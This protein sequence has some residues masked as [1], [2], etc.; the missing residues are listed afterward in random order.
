MVPP[1]R[2][3][4][5]RRS[6]AVGWGAVV[7]AAL[8]VTGGTIRGCSSAGRAGPRADASGRLPGASGVVSGE[9]PTVALGEPSASA[10]SA[11]WEEAAETIVAE[12][13][14][15][16]EGRP[17]AGAFAEAQAEASREDLARYPPDRSQLRRM[18]LGTEG[19]RARALAALSARPVLDDD[20]AALVLRS[21]RPE[22]DPLIR[23]LAAE[24]VAAMP[25]DVL[26]RHEEELLRAFAAEENP[27]ILAVAL[28]SLEQLA[29]PRLEQLL[30]AQLEL[31]SAPMLPVLVGVAR[32]RLGA[33]ALA[34][35]G[36]LVI[37]PG[38][39]LA[40]GE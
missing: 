39:A 35:V 12:L 19:E 34:Q 10:L 22:D 30:R 14:G 26:S 36:V 2:A 24:V 28:P 7:V 38:T 40:S 18:L 37:A 11:G 3:T 9:P 33:D 4:R 29:A 6:V 15:L 8:L 1:R 21:H 32:D 13:R 5:R 31:A 16:V 27:L 17:R 25:P 23:L 20:L